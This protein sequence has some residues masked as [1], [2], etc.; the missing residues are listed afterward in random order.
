M[1][2]VEIS[3]P[4]YL[5]S[6]HDNEDVIWNVRVCSVVDT[7]TNFRHECMLKAALA[8]WAQPQ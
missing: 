5:V 4:L 7:N 1:N 6:T 3:L 8:I 2:V